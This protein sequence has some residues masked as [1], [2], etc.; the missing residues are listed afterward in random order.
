VP[1]PL[2]STKAS[3]SDN[4]LENGSADARALGY[5]PRVFALFAFCLYS[6]R[7]SQVALSELPVLLPGFAQ[8]GHG[9]RV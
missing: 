3:L 9:K 4:T 5:V 8:Y 2:A 7:K 6:F 1:T